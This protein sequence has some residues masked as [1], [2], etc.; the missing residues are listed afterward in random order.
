[1]FRVD[2]PYQLILILIDYQSWHANS[3]NVTL[4]HLALE[5]YTTWI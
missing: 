2:H 4:K 1:M 5:S 3:F